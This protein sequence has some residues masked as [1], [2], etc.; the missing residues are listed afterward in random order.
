[1]RL[2][3]SGIR[4]ARRTAEAGMALAPHERAP[5][6]RPATGRDRHPQCRQ[7]RRDAR[8]AGAVRPR[9]GLG[10]RA[11]PARA[12]RD[13]HDLRR[14][15]RHQGACRRQGRRPARLRRRFRPLRRCARTAS[16]AST[17]PLGRA[18]QGLLRR[19]WRASTRS[20]D[21]AR[22]DATRTARISSP[23]SCSPGRTA[24]PSSSTA[25]SSARWS[26]RR[27]A[28]SGFGYDPMF[29]PDGHDRTFGEMR[30]EEK[31]G[32]DWQTGEA[33]SHRARAFV[34]LAAA[35]LRAERRVIAKPRR[36]HIRVMTSTGPDHPTRDAGFG[37]Y[38][39]WPFCAAKCPYCDFNSHVRHAA[40]R[41]GRAT[42]T[43]SGREIAHC[44]ARDAR[45]APCSRSSSAA[46]RR[47]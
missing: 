10:R 44:A 13:R 9:A 36:A 32:V 14:E 47:R 2:A 42:S 18:D 21:T 19:A 29:M 22:R 34:L 5:H 24:T 37:V 4:P 43:P 30:A 39:H 27:A 3:E 16:P 31:H 23:R 38:V 1:M 17:P 6:P 26:G 7:A 20:C 46:A 35:C 40:R 8:A 45:A 33:L 25:G 41:R 15:R 11:R 12:R 28:T